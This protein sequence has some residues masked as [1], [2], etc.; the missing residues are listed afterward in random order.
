MKLSD[1][2]S[3]LN[4]LEQEDHT[5]EYAVTLRQLQSVSLTVQR[6]NIQLNS[7]AEDLT[8]NIN[9]VISSFDRAQSTLDALKTQLRERIAEL[10]PEQY[11]ASTLL[12]DQE[13]I[14]ETS[15]NILNRRLAIDDD[16]NILLRSR[17]RNYGDWRLPGMIIR[18]GL[19][20]FI[21][22]MVPLDPLYVV[23]Q[24]QDLIDPA[25]N[26]FTPEYQRRLRPYL[27]DE[28]TNGQPLW[29]L[30]NNQ[31]GLI[32]AYNYF[33]YKPIEVVERYLGDIYNKL[34]PGGA[35][36]FTFND[37][38][39]GHGAALSERSFMCYTPGHAIEAAAENVGYEILNRHHGQGDIAWFELKKPGTIQSIRGGQSLAKIVAQP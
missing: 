23:D 17:L 6:H 5:P 37:C 4:L 22:D 14:Y 16:S 1:L 12:Y 3:Y 15:N 7:F 39:R 29:Q 10:E 24:K 11:T 13:M 38:D 35:F 33:N 2:I 19:D 32:F 36:I 31:F 30:P 25:I 21:E 26:A 8:H 28:R 20:D 18:P 27:I 34:R 9:G